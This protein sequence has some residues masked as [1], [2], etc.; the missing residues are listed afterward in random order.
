MTDS[1]EFISIQKFPLSVSKE[2][3]SGH[4]MRNKRMKY[5]PPRMA[6]LLLSFFVFFA[7]LTA[8]QTTARFLLLQP[9]ARSMAM[10][11]VGSS[12]GDNSFATYYN[13]AALVFLP[14][15]GMTGSFVKPIP[16][17]GS[18]VHS[19]ISTIFRLNAA[20]SFGI[21]GNIYQRSKQGMTGFFGDAF[22]EKH[23]SVSWQGKLSYSHL[24][25][26]NFSCGASAEIGRAHV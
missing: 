3:R 1:I 20:N 17:F 8:Q 21:S 24:L 4:F 26:D 18:T 13:P 6:I 14:S 25:S 9:S 23:Y 15:F 5:I 11:G 16:F 10:G 2:Y 7:Q 12:L 22:P 19:F